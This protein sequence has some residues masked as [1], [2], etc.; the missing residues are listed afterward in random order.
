MAECRMRTATML[1]ASRSRKLIA[2]AAE[3]RAR[4]DSDVDRRDVN[5]AAGGKLALF[6]D[7]TPKPG[8]HVYAPGSKDYIPIA[9]KLNAAARGQGR[10]AGV[11]EVAR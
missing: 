2:L 1:V 11:S 9:L 5:G 6:V 8:I 4:H 7:V 10:Q 3:A